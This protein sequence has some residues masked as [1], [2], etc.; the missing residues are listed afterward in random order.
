MR[1]NIVVISILIV[2]EKQNKHVH[3]FGNWE[4]MVQTCPNLFSH[5]LS[6]IWLSLTMIQTQS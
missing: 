5:F 1:V 3:S 6:I 2:N 4:R